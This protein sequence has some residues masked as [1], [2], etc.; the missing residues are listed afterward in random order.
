MPNLHCFGGFFDSGKPVTST[1]APR[2][3]TRFFRFLYPV[4]VHLLKYSCSA[5]IIFTGIITQYRYTDP[6]MQVFQVSWPTFRSSAQISWFSLHHFLRYYYPILGTP[7][8]KM[9]VFSAGKPGTLTIVRVL[10][11]TKSALLFEV[12]WPT[13]L[14][15]VPK[16]MKPGMRASLPASVLTNDRYRTWIRSSNKSIY[17][18]SVGRSVVN[19][20]ACNKQH[21][22][23]VSMYYSVWWHIAESEGHTRPPSIKKRW[24]ALRCPTEQE[25]NLVKTFTARVG[26]AA[27]EQTKCHQTL[28]HRTMNYH[29]QLVFSRLL[30]VISLSL[31]IF[32]ILQRVCLQNNF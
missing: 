26:S 20:N 3:S 14:F 27:S 5:Y 9:Q 24:L 15:R 16:V 21:E 11:S 29:Q 25:N 19:C 2:K 13:P 30:L 12:S 8:L 1:H 7:T 4:P 18:D 23:D 17:Y 10:Q 31:S 28:S 32:V 6:K 22:A